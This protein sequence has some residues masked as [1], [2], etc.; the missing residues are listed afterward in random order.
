[1]TI[2]SSSRAI[3]QIEPVLNSSENISLTEINTD[4]NEAGASVHL[5]MDVPPNGGYGWVNVACVFL[6]N[7]HTWG[8]NSVSDVSPYMTSF[9]YS[10]LVLLHL[11]NPSLISSVLRCIPS[12]LPLQTNILRRISPR[13]CL[14][15]RTFC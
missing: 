3:E 7:A 14:R 5:A 2:E 13:L 6:I 12:L 4:A 9:I 11:H 10:V 8:V 15:W 1:M